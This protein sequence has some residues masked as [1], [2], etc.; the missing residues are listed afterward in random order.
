MPS[1]S[2]SPSPPLTMEGLDPVSSLCT[3]RHPGNVLTGAYVRLLREHF[4]RVENLEYNMVNEFRSELEQFIWNPELDKT[5]IQIDAVWKYNAQDLQR[6]PGL[7]VKRNNF[8]YQQVAINQG[9]TVN[10]TR[11][12]NGT[13]ENVPGDYKTVAV[14]GS[15]TIFCVGGS[16][17]EAELLGAEVGNHF[18][19]F[20]PILRSDLK[21]HKFMVTQ[22][23]EVSLLDEAVEHF[24]VPV[25]LGYAA[26]YA[27]RLNTVAPWLKTLAIDVKAT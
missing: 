15:H 16:G 2:P 21:L 6:R 27:W 11:G 25:V 1:Q 3:T 17:A 14:I 10:A 7:Y 23:E 19:G 12:K 5:G 20:G 18:Q 22:V 8:Q 24:V 26:F 4:A 9:M 13:V